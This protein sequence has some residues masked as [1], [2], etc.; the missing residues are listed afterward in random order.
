MTYTHKIRSCKGALVISIR[1]F[2]WVFVFSLFMALLTTSCLHTRTNAGTFTGMPGR[3]QITIVEGNAMLSIQGHVN[4]DVYSWIANELSVVLRDERLEHPVVPA[5][6]IT[7]NE[8]RHLFTGE[9][10]IFSMVPSEIVIVNIVSLD[11]N[12]VK[13]TSH[14]TRIGVRTHILAEGNRMGITVAFLAR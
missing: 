9:E 3:A 8:T 7:R 6:T 12:S 1:K 11:G 14:D 5:G 10:I 2:L 4:R 13:I